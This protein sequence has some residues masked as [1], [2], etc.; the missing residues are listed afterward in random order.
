MQN[1]TAAE[2][3]ELIEQ[4]HIPK[5]IIAALAE[6]HPQ[7]V[8]AFSN[9]IPAVSEAKVIRISLT[10][11]ELVAFVAAQPFPPALSIKHIDRLR[12][13]I[14]DFRVQIIQQHG[15]NAKYVRAEERPVEPKEVAT[16]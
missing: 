16:K 8:S 14:G 3:N 5:I 1:I 11:K 12:R 2:F 9:A 10:T 7:D 15:E 6:V 13:A 4:H